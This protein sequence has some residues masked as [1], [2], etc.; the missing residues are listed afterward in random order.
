MPGIE[1]RSL[2][3]D[4]AVV[5]TRYVVRVRDPERGKYTSATFATRP[6]AERFVRDCDDRS[7]AW[8]LA[9]Y[10]REKVE[11][12]EKTLN[13]WAELHFDS[14]TKAAP[15]TVARYRRQYEA[16]WRPHLGHMRLSAIER[17]HVARAL[18]AQAGS[19][20][21][22]LNAWA[23][24]THMLKMAAQDGLIQRSPTIGVRP[25][26]R[27]EHEKAEHRYLTVDEYQA[28]LDATP[29]FWKPVIVMLAASGMRWGELVALNVSDLDLTTGAV[30]ITKAEKRDDSV[31]GGLV[32]GPPKSKKARRTVIL[33]AEALPWLEPLTRD[34][35]GK[36]RRRDERLFTAPRGGNVRHRTFYRLVWLNAITKS[37]IAEPRPRLHDLRHSHVAWLIAAGV[38]LPVI[39]ARLGHEKITT[40][41]DTYGHLMPDLMQAAADA[42]SLV[43][44][45]VRKAIG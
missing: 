19:D 20:K 29:E 2:R 39:Q 9:E 5:G 13:E 45:G 14:L 36:P 31:P 21:T 43:F 22:V 1:E 6:E 33:P 35:A 18:N 4:G 7:V 38:P 40:T 30:R 44:S 42:A 15:G 34:D 8:A 25:G 10:R 26:R 32:I 28:V 16:R 37:G 17:V 23:V 41:I 3:R 12:D 24:L 27:T 11:A